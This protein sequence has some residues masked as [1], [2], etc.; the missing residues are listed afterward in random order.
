MIPLFK[1]RYQ[2]SIQGPRPD[3]NVI[4][5][6]FLNDATFQ[7]KIPKFESAPTRVPSPW[8][9]GPRPDGNVIPSLFLNDPTFQ[10]K[11]PKFESAPTRVP[12]PW[13]RGPRPDGNVI[14]T[15]FLNDPTFQIKIPKFESA[16]T[17]VPS[18]W[19]RGPR[20]DGNV[21]PSLFP[22]DPTF[23][24]KIPKLDSGPT[25]WWQRDPNFIPK[26]SHFWNQDTKTRISSHQGTQP[27]NRG[28]RP[29]GNVIPSLFPNDPTFQ[30]KIPKLDSGPTAWWQ[31]DPNFIPKWSHFWNQDTKTRI[32]SHQGT[33]PRNRG[34][35]PD[36]N[37]IPS[38]FLNDPTFQ[39]KIPKLDSGPT[40]WWQRDPNFIPKWCHFSN[41]DTKIRISS[42][43]G[44]QPLE[45]GP[46][47]WW[48]RD[49][50]FIPKWSHFSNQ[51]T[52]IR[53]SSHQGTQPLESG[54]TAWWQR[55]PNFI[56]KWSHFSNQD[57][58][59]RISSHQGTQPLESG[60]T[61]WWQRDPNF[62]PKWSHFS[63][64]DTKSPI[65]KFLYGSFQMITKKDYWNS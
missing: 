30:I 14:P 20:P 16:P 60:P 32:S 47:A 45:S 2:N 39:I 18:P 54:P 49:P 9:R 61:A 28:P 37:V 52:K 21:I 64:Q 31:R 51:D 17:R 19:N 23:Q 42:H 26:W 8:N 15:L 43:Q 22:N 56:P 44:T 40:A 36:G 11:I 27:R 33:Q 46:T 63:N 3:G 53:I 7:I 50:K 13:N 48:Q 10:I 12:S 58:K 5:T 24:I 57:T 4:P 62:I 41:Q 59:I 1:S 25:A 34:P 35:R 6:L 38:L 55:D 29:D 65:R